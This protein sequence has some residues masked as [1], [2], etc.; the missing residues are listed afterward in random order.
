MERASEQGA[1]KTSTT[2]GDTVF[3]NI[4][5]SVRTRFDLE[6]A[7]SMASNP[8]DVKEELLDYSDLEDEVQCLDNM[9]TS[10]AV[11]DDPDEDEEPS[12]AERK[13]AQVRH[14]QQE[15]R[16][17]RDA[18][19]KRD[20]EDS[21]SSNSIAD[22]SGESVK[23]TTS[24]SKCNEQLPVK[25]TSI[26]LGSGY[27]TVR[28]ARRAAWSQRQLNQFPVCTEKMPLGAL[29]GGMAGFSSVCV[30]MTCVIDLTSR[31]HSTLTVSSALSARGV[32]I[33]H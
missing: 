30:C 10:G 15:S 12:E 13:L 19:A 7:V 8:R 9:D 25:M 1:A 11:F 23:V 18:D 24:V 26:N 29:R 32:G 22:A 17:R 31:C 28:A 6:R 3:S 5:A 20:Q 27:N 14:Q 2:A 33:R 4:M 16:D 21:S